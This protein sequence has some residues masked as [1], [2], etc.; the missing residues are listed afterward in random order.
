[1]STVA[2]GGLP[3]GIG[4]IATVISAEPAVAPTRPE[5]V[6]AELVIRDD[7]VFRLVSDSAGAA[8]VPAVDPR[9]DAELPAAALT[10]LGSP[11]LAAALAARDYPA[12]L[13][14]LA[15]GVVVV[16]V[17]HAETGLQALGV[18][19]EGG[20]L[21]CCI[22]SSAATLETFVADSTER[23]FVTRAGAAV[24]EFV[25]AEADRLSRLV[26]DP[27]GP[28]PMAIRVADLVAILSVP[29]GEV[30]PALDDPALPAD[31]AGFEVPLD[32]NWGVLD[33]SADAASRGDQIKQLVKV[34]TRSLSDQGASLRHDMR[35]WLTR[36]ADQ[37]ASAGGRQFAF[38]LAHTK[39]AAAAV[40]MVS[41]WHELGAG[42][43]AE[44]PIDRLGDHL[45]DT[46][47]AADELVKLDVAGD[48]VIRHTR[49]RHGN[50]ELGGG[51]I[52]LL[53]IDYWVAV[54]QEGASS[55]AHVSFS[56]P[57]V[58]AKDAIQTLA[59]TLVLA[60]TWVAAEEAAA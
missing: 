9:I 42:V 40:T 46:A 57:H 35:G 39:Q 23:S 4:S 3:A 31:I 36:T 45:V 25:V 59:D 44:S 16:P 29:T 13:E 10:E 18:G 41:Y 58:P 52:P 48:R 55:L 50:A 19:G 12:V 5:L 37:A 17:L 8:A 6:D 27:A 11:E 51:E 56:S 60:G 33:L 38:L 7:L 14:A 47:D 21:D 54:P 43:G 32:A 53:L 28:H 15:Y 49:V 1:M 34:Q 24:V 26:I 30:E 2:L 20:G 22:F